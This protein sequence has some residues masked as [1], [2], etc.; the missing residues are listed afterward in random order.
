MKFVCLLAAIW[1]AVNSAVADTPSIR[2]PNIVFIIAD[3]MHRHMFNCLP[4]GRHPRGKAKNLTPAI[5]RLATEGTLM[6]GQHCSAPVCTPSRYSCLTGLYAS[7][8]KS[9]NFIGETE[10]E[11]QSVVQWTSFITDENTLP[12]RLKRAGYR[13]GFVGKNHVFQGDIEKVGYDEDPRDPEVAERLRRRQQQATKMIRHGGFD[14]VSRLY[15]ENPDHNGPRELAVHNMDWTTDGALDF[16]NHEKDK[17]FFLYY[18]TTTPHGPGE[19]DRSWNA[20]P[21]IIP[22]GYLDK[23]LDVLPPRESIPKR[24]T[25]AG[26]RPDSARCNLLWLDDSVAAIMAKLRQYEIDDN[27]IIVFFNDHGQAAKGTLYQGGVSSPSII[28]KKDGFSAGSVNETAVSNIDFAPTLLDL[29]GVDYDANDFDG[30]SFASV[31]KQESTSPNDRN[32]MYFEMG[33]S[34]AVVKDGWKYLALRYPSRADGMTTVRRQRILDRFN[35]DQKHRGRPIYTHDASTPFSHISMIP[36][37]GDAEAM[38]TGKRPGYYDKD[39]LYDLSRDPDEQNN[40]ASDPEFA[41]KLGEMKA[42]LQKYLVDLPGGFAELKPTPNEIIADDSSDVI[43]AANKN[44]VQQET[45]VISNSDMHDHSYHTDEFVVHSNLWGAHAM[46]DDVPNFQFELSHDSS[47]SLS[48]PAYRWS[49]SE[50]FSKPIFPFIGYGDRMWDKKRKS[51]T[52]RLPIQLKDLGQCDLHYQLSIDQESFR[53]A[54]GNLAVDVWLGDAEV[55]NDDSMRTEIMLWFDRNDQ[56]PVGGR[57]HE[58]TYTFGGATWDLYIGELSGTGTIVNTFIAQSPVYEGIV[59]FMV[60][61]EIIKTK[62]RIDDSTYLGGF[63]LGNEIYLGKGRTEVQQFHIDV[64]PKSFPESHVQKAWMFSDQ[65]TGKRRFNGKNGIT[66]KTSIADTGGI[67]VRFR[68]DHYD[69][70]QVIYKQGDHASGLAIAMNRGEVQFIHWNTIEGETKQSVLSKEANDDSYIVAACQIN[71]DADTVT[72]FINGVSIGSK[73]YYGFIDN[74]SSISIGFSDIPLP[75]GV[76]DKDG[77]V[78]FVGVIDDV[79]LFDRNVTGADLEGME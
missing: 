42:E 71:Q 74:E 48:L 41:G 66:E 55:A 79:I 5:D 77:S 29:A 28:W 44:S 23:P 31:L 68:A 52:S 37:G 78:P 35:A 39:Q 18:A 22:T 15:Y 2:P 26:L 69:A 38:S 54:K 21:R 61:L 51:T 36:G 40:L 57:N 34:R 67:A 64:Q 16:I 8:S 3:D 50:P 73:P 47:N 49:I 17:P 10:R 65:P 53:S 58:G 63:E 13:T 43:P 75:A 6:L 24:I 19:P 33:Y 11:G 62:G 25:D 46:K 76:T 32:S 45:H 20:D 14:V 72:A 56:Y 12:K 59:D 7:R 70:D 27:T 60:P 9:P 4:E 30:Q 1:F